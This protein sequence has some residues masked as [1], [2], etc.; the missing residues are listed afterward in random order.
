MQDIAIE[1]RELKKR[2]GNLW[3]LNGINLKIPRGSFISILGPNGAGKTT[4]LEIIEG[5]QKPTKGIIKIFNKEW[6]ED[7]ELFLKRKIGLC[8]QETRFV[9]K[10]TVREIL[11]VFASIY[12]I[13]NQRIEEILELLNL[14]NKQN[15]YTE[16]L[17]GGQKQR[18]ALAI[19]I[20]HEP[21]IL[22]LDE[23]TTG[24][25]PDAR[26]Q[27]WDILLYF[28]KKNKTII[29]TT[30]YMEESEQLSDY[31]YLI[32]QGRIIA[33]GTLNELLKKY[34]K[35][36]KLIFH[37]EKLNNL[38]KKRIMN[39][40]NNHKNYQYEFFNDDQGLKIILHE[41]DHL[42]PTLENWIGI[43]KNLKLKIHDVQIHRS[44]LNDI[45]LYLTG[46]ELDKYG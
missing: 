29:M 41:N 28:K 46:R 22:F 14:K 42:I 38:K 35:F 33:E 26:K 20:L 27:I 34:G 39:I 44:N 2:F 7:N 4:L 21:E 11:K 12:D 37:F 10:L 6:N 3:V 15:T 36:I 17:S 8:L 32:N 16:H 25:D 30:H 1:V 18:L 23:P 31:I 45:F 40:L 5:L 9:D 43:L 19:S 13:S 24:L